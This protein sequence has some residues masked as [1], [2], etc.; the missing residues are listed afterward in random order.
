ML[1]DCEPPS[2][3]HYALTQLRQDVME[4]KNMMIVPFSMTA[5]NCEIII[6]CSLILNKTSHPYSSHDSV[7]ILNASNVRSISLVL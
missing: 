1:A 5:A 7:C 3:Y 4:E 2:S 6:T